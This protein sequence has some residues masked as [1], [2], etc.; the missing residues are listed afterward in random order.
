MKRREGATAGV[1][2][3]TTAVLSE[4]ALYFLIKRRA[5]T[6]TNGLSAPDWTSFFPPGTRPDV[7]AEPHYVDQ[8]G[9]ITR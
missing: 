5:K 8:T 1:Y 6:G 7:Y 4:V 3:I 9:G 2:L